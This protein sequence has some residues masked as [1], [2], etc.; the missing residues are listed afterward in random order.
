MTNDLTTLNYEELTAL[1]DQLQ[2]DSKEADTN[3]QAMLYLNL[4]N[5]IVAVRAQLAKVK[6]KAEKV[7]KPAGEQK[8]LF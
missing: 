7:E 6:P 2:Q 1:L 4:E 5:R 3:G 8:R